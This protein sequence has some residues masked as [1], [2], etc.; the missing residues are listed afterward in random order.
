MTQKSLPFPRELIEEIVRQHPTPFHL[1]DEAGIRRT[2][3]AFY[4]AF[5]WVPGGF[6]NYFAVKALPN[7]YIVELLK[8]EGMGADCSSLPE[9]LI[10]ESTGLPAAAAFPPM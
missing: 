5:A 6:L 10:A 3:R 7:P 9:L 4:D 1:Y 2:A 8:G